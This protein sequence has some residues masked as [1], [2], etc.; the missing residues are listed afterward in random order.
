MKFTALDVP[1]R[2][3]AGRGLEKEGKRPYL[4]VL[5]AGRT[6]PDQIII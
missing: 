6:M 1:Q 2:N 4:T 3:L 5:V